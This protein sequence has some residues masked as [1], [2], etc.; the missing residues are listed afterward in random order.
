M[1]GNYLMKGLDSSPSLMAV[2]PPP[3][4]VSGKALADLVE[5]LVGCVWDTCG[6]A[7]ATRVMSWLGLP[8]GLSGF[9]GED[10]GLREDG[11]EAR[12]VCGG[13]GG[14]K[15][16]I[17]EGNAGEVCAGGNGEKTVEGIGA[18]GSS[19]D[20]V[21]VDENGG[22]EGEEGR[23]GGEEEAGEEGE[24]G[25]GEVGEKGLAGVREIEAALGYEFRDKRLVL[26][27]LTH[28]SFV[29]WASDEVVTC[30][31]RL[32]FLGDAF[33]DYF[34]TR[35]LHLQHPHQTPRQL[36]FRR[37]ALVNNENLSRIATSA[38]SSAAATS[39]GGSG[40]TSMEVS[41]KGFADSAVGEGEM[42]EEGGGRA[43]GKERKE[44]EREEEGG[45]EGEEERR[46][47][48][49]DGYFGEGGVQAPKLSSL[50]VLSLASHLNPKPHTTQ[51]I[52]DVLESL[53]EATQEVDCGIDAAFA[54]CLLYD[55]YL[56]PFS[57]YVL[58]TTT[59]AIAGVLESLAIGD[60]LESLAI[61][62]VLESLVGATLVDCGFDTERVWG[63]FSR[64]FPPTS[65]VPLSFSRLPQ[66]HHLGDRRRAGVP[67]GGNA[68]GL[69]V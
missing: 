52:G 3:V 23:M 48:K 47:E 68:S 32:E 16:G 31:Q 19:I 66:P 30:Y 45:E 11:G 8:V 61:G 5:A 4:R 53:V 12:E 18:R 21:M 24:E 20:E 38:V 29:N 56:S 15:G 55:V 27:A 67:G 13:M 25:G 58:P 65:T 2:S 63:L 22:K 33:I 35:Q 39:A 60:V 42:V 28:P 14:R 10:G 43:Q 7:A 17:V 34:V 51:A 59:Q 6:A 36:T 69:W 64:F 40:M 9:E 41:H 26:E 49:L 50:H 62:D 57:P 37:A 1:G 46:R 44:A 54:L